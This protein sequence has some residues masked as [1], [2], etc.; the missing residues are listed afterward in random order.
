MHPTHD[1][2]VQL[3][4]TAT[5]PSDFDVTVR[6]SKKR[7][8]SHPQQL[9]A[10]RRLAR[11]CELQ[12]KMS[13]ARLFLLIA[14]VLVATCQAVTV[15]VTEVIAPA[16]VQLTRHILCIT[17]LS[18][19]WTL[20]AAVSPLYAFLHSLVDAIRCSLSSLS[21]SALSCGRYPLSTYL[22]TSHAGADRVRRCGQG[23]CWPIPFHA[24]HGID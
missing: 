12:I 20:S 6:R 23:S 13:I 17:A 10:C 15:T 4:G 19:L 3:A 7:K 22:Y 11:V 21:F 16:V 1:L 24:L 2:G 5:K 14:V 8:N 18:S 9:V